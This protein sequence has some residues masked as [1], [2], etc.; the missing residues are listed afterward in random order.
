MNW[1]NKTGYTFQSR[2]FLFTAA[3]SRLSEFCYKAPCVGILWE[4][5][6]ERAISRI[7]PWFTHRIAREDKNEKYLE[8][9][10][11]V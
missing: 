8:I 6:R 11:A 1:R 9:I 3:R 7:L 5:A 4:I 2:P 10:L